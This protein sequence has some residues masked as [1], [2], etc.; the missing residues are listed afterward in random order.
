MLH[1]AL[2][3]GRLTLRNRLV[4]TAHLTG[5]ATDGLPTREHAAYYAARAAGGA[6][7]VITEEHSVHPHDRP[8]EKLIRGHDPAVL[9]GYRALT[10]AV[11]A[12]GA[13]VLAQL[14][15]NGPQSSGMYSRE[16]VRG[17]SAVPD[18]MFREVPVAMTE[19]D[20]D[21]VVAGYARTARHCV[22]GGFDGVELQCSHASLVRCFLSPATNHRDDVYGG[23][24]ENRARL[25]LRIVAAVRRELGGRVLGVRI[26]GEEGIEGG[27]GL[28]AGVALARLLERTGEVD[29]LNTS[30]GVATASLHL[31]E[32]SMHTP[33]DY[34]T[35]IPSAIRAAVRLP[36]VAVGRFTEPA[37]AERAL[38]EGHCDLVGVARGQIASPDF[39]APAGPTRVC[40]GCNQDCVGRVGMN[41]PLRCAVNPR[42]GREAV[43]LPAPGV[44]RRVV[45]VGGGPAGLR[46]A[47]TAAARGHRVTLYERDRPGG[48]LAL[49]ALAPGR[50]E[51]AHVVRDLL[52]ECERAGVEIVHGEP[53]DLGSADAVVLATGAR[54]ARRPGTVDVR[55]VL[56]GTAAP[57]GAVLVVDELGFH[58]ATSVAELLAARGCTV[59]IVTPGMVVGQDLG[60]TLDREGFRRRAH[61]AGIRL[62]TARLVTAVEPGRA[63]LVHH[64]TGRSETREVDAVVCAVPAEPDDA[65]WS[66]LRHRAGV[67]RI[68]DCLAPRRMDAALRDGERLAVSL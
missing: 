28:D 24:L 42:A 39:A 54:P 51:L 46:A 36:V 58:H 41:R 49:A 3:A 4:F 47:A 23:T 43:P 32:A 14:N 63:T 37:V 31:I 30:I 50:G 53:G 18:P 52:G 11:H 8:Y 29:H 21:D 35:F 65:L 60:L 9:P 57:T 34:A 10:D 61:A 2:R 13:V 22:E 25:L 19:A 45:V 55:D 16:P 38:V 56:A 1:E 48:Q 17:P 44:P 27:I 59:E 5:Y 40:V 64:P 15:H 62:T 20:L 67:H 12:H 68:G 6:G 33:A 26:G 66:T 7:M